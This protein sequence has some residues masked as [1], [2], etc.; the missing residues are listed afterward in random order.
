VA[1]NRRLPN[2]IMIAGRGK[3]EVTAVAPEFFHGDLRPI[4][5]EQF[6][7]EACTLNLSKV[8]LSQ[9]KHLFI[10]GLHLRQLLQQN[11]NIVHCWEEPYTLAGGQLAWWT[12][13]ESR[14]VFWTGQTIDRRY[15]PPFARLER[16]CFERCA[17]W[18]ARGD[19]GVAAMQR[20]GHGNK[21]HQ[22]IPLGVDVNHFRPDREAR[23]WI[24]DR[25][26]WQARD[27]PIV[28]FLGRFVEE[29]GLQTLTDTLDQVK[30]PWRALLVG[31]GPMEANLREWAVKYGDRIR[32]VTGVQHGEVPAYLNAMDLLCAPSHATPLWQEIFGRMII[33]AFACGVP[34]VASRS[35]EIPNVLG[36][37]GILV[38]EN[39]SK[40]WV[41]SLV[42]LITDPALR[43]CL[44]GQGIARVHAKFSWPTVA[45]QYITFFSRLLDNDR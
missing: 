33:E 29:K 9:F 34:V 39:N 10:Y 12:P 1:L 30:E 8:Y 6:K 17:G 38:D 44:A 4:Y 11:W 2:E 28:G 42:S 22:A 20:R 5:L 19:L 16:Y 25:L 43:K 41:R 32:I 45:Q 40:E 27:E 21:P 24:L 37:A 26:E 18:L 15:P 35:G 7:D 13:E 3:W 31:S 14:F 36:E 23:R